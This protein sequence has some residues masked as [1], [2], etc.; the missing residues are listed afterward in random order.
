MFAWYRRRKYRQKV[1]A[2]IGELLRLFP[3][4]HKS[5]HR[6]QKR[7]ATE[8][9]EDG[10]ASNDNP[11]EL[12]LAITTGYLTAFLEHDLSAE[13]RA[14]FLRNWVECQ[15]GFWIALTHLCSVAYGLIRDFGVNYWAMDV[16][17]DEVLDTLRGIRPEQR[18]INRTRDYRERMKPENR[19]H[20]AEFLRS[21][22]LDRKE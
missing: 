15:G 22:S 18:R 17:I 16:C 9:I 19:R 6:D 3:G 10:F 21:L 12:G 11:H 5:A 20:A 2:T 4:V 13:T 7:A 14:E 1:E 8:A